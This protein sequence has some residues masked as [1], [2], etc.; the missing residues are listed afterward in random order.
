MARSPRKS[1][2]PPPLHAANLEERLK[3]LGRSRNRIAKLT[4]KK[5]KCNK[6]TRKLRGER[7]KFLTNVNTML[8]E[9]DELIGSGGEIYV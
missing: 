4:K 9:F 7:N 8:S 5:A 3:N 1:T 6:Q 2:P